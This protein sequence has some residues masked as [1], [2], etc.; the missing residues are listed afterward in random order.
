MTKRWEAVAARMVA[1]RKQLGLSYQALAERTGLTKSTL[2]RY[3]KGSIKNAPIA[4]L[5]D[6]C[7]GLEMSVEELMGLQGRRD[8]DGPNRQA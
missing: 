8:S 5:E 4:R 7:R 1:R 6:L 3:E 2:Q